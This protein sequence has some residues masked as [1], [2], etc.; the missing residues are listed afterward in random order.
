MITIHTI[1]KISYAQ[2][3]AF[4]TEQI[5]KGVYPQKVISLEDCH[6][7]LEVT[8]SA[9]FN[10]MKAK[11]KWFQLQEYD[12]GDPDNQNAVKAIQI[13]EEDF[14]L[15]SAEL[16]Q[17]NKLIKMNIMWETDLLDEKY[18]EILTAGIIIWC[19]TIRQIFGLGNADFEV[20]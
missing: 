6:W 11:V 4:N 16:D 8:D 1:P 10:G 17:I 13:Y 14:V 2:A 9:P 3:F 5:A 15:T 18:N 20:Q 7:R 12:A 19:G